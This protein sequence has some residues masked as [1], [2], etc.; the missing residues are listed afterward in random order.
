MIDNAEYPEPGFGHLDFQRGRIINYPVKFRVPELCVSS[1]NRNIAICPCRVKKV[2]ARY[3]RVAVVVS[4]NPDG[5]TAAAL[6]KA[7]QVK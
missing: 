1:R 6:N 7:W 4:K 2:A 5:M 3:R